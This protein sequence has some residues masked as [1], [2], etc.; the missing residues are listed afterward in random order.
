MSDKKNFTAQ[1]AV[2]WSFEVKSNQLY[3]KSPLAQFKYKDDNLSERH[4][5]LLERF[6]TKDIGD[7]RKL[8]KTLD[9][10]DSSDIAMEEISEMCLENDIVSPEI[11]LMDVMFSNELKTASRNGITLLNIDDSLEIRN[12]EEKFLSPEE[13]DLLK[14]YLVGEDDVPPGLQGIDIGRGETTTTSGGSGGVTTSGGGGVGGSF[15]GELK[16]VDISTSQNGDVEYEY[17]VQM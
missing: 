13:T 12:G 9:T 1:D 3:G 4:E 11:L 15:Q 10:F 14:E 2:E 7:I 17:E 16:S 6:P 5:D 8:E